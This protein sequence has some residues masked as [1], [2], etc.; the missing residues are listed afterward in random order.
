MY[1]QCRTLFM[2]QYI[3]SKVWSRKLFAFS[4]I[5]LKANFREL[6][7]FI[8]VSSITISYA[9]YKVQLSN[10][11]DFEHF[12]IVFRVKRKLLRIFLIYLKRKSWRICMCH[13]NCDAFYCTMWD[14]RVVRGN[15]ALH[16]RMCDLNK[17]IYHWISVIV[18]R[19]PTLSPSSS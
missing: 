1:N 14:S 11:H 4:G 8:F 17:N 19:Y 7:I 10:Y 12:R 9:H 15:E 5:I 6:F 3:V 18:H 13:S 16:N 2:S